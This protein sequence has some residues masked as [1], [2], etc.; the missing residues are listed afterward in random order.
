MIRNLIETTVRASL[1]RKLY[2]A[3]Y[4]LPA[5]YFLRRSIILFI[6]LRI[7][8]QHDVNERFVTTTEVCT[9]VVYYYHPQHSCSK[10]IFL[11]LSA[12]LS[13]GGGG[14]PS[15][16]LGR[17]PQAD[18]PRHT[19]PRQTPPWADTPRQIPLR[20][21]LLQQTVRILLECI[22]VLLSNLTT[23]KH[24]SSFKA[25]YTCTLDS[26]YSETNH[27]NRQ[28]N[29]CLKVWFALPLNCFQWKVTK[30]EIY[31]KNKVKFWQKLLS[32]LI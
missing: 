31:S 29:P 10:V 17:H 6:K 30:N 4:I 27:W 22:L 32:N 7:V 9:F 1:L 25:D 2:Q 5:T 28:S 15:M 21:R 8:E 14:F 19:P 16:H 18:T 20:R 13:T 3:V 12:I 23:M 24:V 11:H 26:F